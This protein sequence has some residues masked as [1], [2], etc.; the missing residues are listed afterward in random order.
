MTDAQLTALSMIAWIIGTATA[1]I[2]LAHWSAVGSWGISSAI[3]RGV[4][5][6]TGRNGVIAGEWPDADLPDMREPDV[7][8]LW[9]GQPR[10]A[11]D[12]ASL[13][14][15]GRAA[16]LPGAEIEDL[17]SRRIGSP[18][19]RAEEVAQVDAVVV[20]VDVEPVAAEEADQGHAQA[21]GEAD[22]EIRRG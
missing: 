1:F 7:D 6:W 10:S 2:L 22:R 16:A 20:R 19:L 5:G 13:T 4:I 12:T 17:G 9:A 15:L 11:P 18:G 21:V 3:A 8:R 14:D